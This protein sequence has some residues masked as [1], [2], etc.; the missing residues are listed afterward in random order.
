[1]PL[2]LSTAV[3]SLDSSSPSPPAAGNHRQHQVHFPPT[4][5]VDFIVHYGHTDFHCHTFVLH[6]QSSYFRHVFDA[7]TPSVSPLPPP[8]SLPPSSG[9]AASGDVKTHV[10]LSAVASP[11]S[12]PSS[13]PQP[14]WRSVLSTTTSYVQSALQRLTA[15]SDTS[16]RKRKRNVKEDEEDE[17]EQSEESVTSKRPT[18]SAAAT[19]AAASSAASSS[20]ACVH[21]GALCAHTA[22]AY[23]D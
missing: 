23:H 10:E 12:S 4:Q 2:S 18:L 19:A 1:M 14:V 22:T 16:G 15:H 11:T 13:P 20:A 6:L 7:L 8:P 9:D 21:P 5:R 3:K 17:D